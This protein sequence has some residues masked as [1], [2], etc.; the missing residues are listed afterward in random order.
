MNPT[1]NVSQAEARE[2]MCGYLSARGYIDKCA[3][4]WYSIKIKHDLG[5]VAAYA[6]YEYRVDPVTSTQ[7]IKEFIGGG[8]HYDSVAPTRETPKNVVVLSDVVGNPS[9]FLR[10]AFEAAGV[11]SEDG[12]TIRIG[13]LTP[14]VHAKF[15]NYITGVGVPYQLTN[16]NL[17][18]TGASAYELLYKI[19]ANTALVSESAVDLFNKY[20]PMYS[21]LLDDPARFVKLLPEAIA[22]FRKSPMDAGWDLHLI[23]VAKELDGGRV[24]VFR[25][26]I[27]VAPPSGH[28]F[29]I[30]VRSS[31]AGSGWALANAIGVIDQGYRGEIMVALRRCHEGA[32]MPQLPFRGVQLLL[33]RQLEYD[34]V[35]SSSL[36][37]TS[38]GD[39]G[40]L[41]S[42]TM[43]AKP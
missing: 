33:R 9:A 29:E 30:V 15:L 7:Y 4:G 40:G 8:V 21:K 20:R 11:G 34:W 24:I 13:I 41:G 32:T 28:Y 26:G 1:I 17:V 42:A 27:A 6:G 25:T 10:G 19:T 2:F 18:Y 3:D 23:D 22:P 16:G 14:T 36:D 35:E 5:F 37:G 39:T 38:R 43:I 31:L 12:V